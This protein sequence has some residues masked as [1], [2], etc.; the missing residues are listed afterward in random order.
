MLSGYLSMLCTN[1][2][3]LIKLFKLF[4]KNQLLFLVKHCV[5]SAVPLGYWGKHKAR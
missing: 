3:A 4:W 2:G 5:S 1:S